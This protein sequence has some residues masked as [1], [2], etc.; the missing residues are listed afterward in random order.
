MKI[1]KPILFAMIFIFSVVACNN[2]T[3][4]LLGDY[5]TPYQTPPFGQ[6][7]HEHYIPAVDSAISLARA[8][9]DEII[10]ST[11]EPTFE[12]TIVEMDKG[13]K[14]LS[15]IT[16]ILFNLNSCETDS[17]LQKIVREVAPKLTDF[18]NDI[19]LNPKL[20]EKVKR[21]YEK[22]DTLN[23]SAEQK[24]LLDKT[25]KGFVRNGA[26]L[27]E[28]QKERYRVITRD[29][30]DLSLQFDENLLAES[31]AYQLHITN[32]DD[33]AG[34]PQSLIDA[35]AMVAKDKGKDGWMI[36]LDIPMYLPFMK[37]SEKRELREQLFKAYNSKCFKGNERDNQNIIKRIVE[38]RLEQ[39]KLLGYENFSTFVL[40]E[41]MAESSE[42][43]NKFLKQLEDA[44]IPAARRELEEVT[45]F[46]KKLGFTDKLQKWDW[47]Y[48]T[49][50]L[51]NQKYS[52]S[53]EELKP[54]FRLENVREGIFKLANMLYGLNFTLNK[55]ISVYHPDVLAYEVTDE[56]KK[57]IGVLYLDFFPREGKNGGAW[58]TSFRSQYKT[59]GQDVR[60]L[61]SIVTNFTKPTDKDPSLLTFNEFST[62]LHEFGHALHGLLSD[63]TYNSLSG[64]SVYRDFVELPSQIMENWAVEKNFLD[65]FAVHYQTGEKIPQELVDKIIN[66]RNF[67]AGYASIRQLG[68]GILDM[69][70]HSMN[71]PFTG[72]VNDF[73]KNQLKALDI[74]PEVK[75]TNIST[76]FSHIF[77][78]G[79]AAGY[80]SYKWAE[81]LDADA[82]SLFKE[83]GIFDKETANSFRTNILSKGGSEHPMILYKRFRGQEPTI[84]ALLVRSGLK[85]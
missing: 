1:L 85:Q 63:V 81:V 51:K 71:D 59:D 74:L 23:L 67:L 13:G 8:E 56:S 77:A 43:V 53:E 29:L 32:A 40:E 20:F 54:Y 12:N 44:S 49:E 60:P 80:Y 38:L 16:N 41:R 34:L 46:A 45:A 48:F 76:S 15:D 55:K 3:N 26:N 19:N 68:F 66:S 72:N 7:K 73:E 21:V 47:S 36:T 30:S 28:S 9:V 22:N 57:F 27:S 39:A 5:K 4:P 84:D 18:S 58:M 83:K 35:A 17:T 6:I 65:L 69:A 14:K 25:Y 64:T 2:N 82:F 42:K 75:G 10:N 78:G 11:D 70:W 79:Y 24:T 31:N 37:Y 50:K 33:L 52:Y 61:I 62:F